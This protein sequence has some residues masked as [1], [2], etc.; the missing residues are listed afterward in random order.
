MFKGVENVTINKNETVLVDDW[1][2][3]VQAAKLYKEASLN[4][5]KLRFFFTL[6]IDYIN[7]IHF[8]LDFNTEI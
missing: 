7:S 2:Y 5:D 8:K 1:G 6:L 3:L 4:K